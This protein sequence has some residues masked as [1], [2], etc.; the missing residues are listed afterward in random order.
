MNK[1]RKCS[2]IKH[3]ESKKSYFRM[4][5]NLNDYQFNIDYDILRMLQMS[6]MVTTKSVIGTEEIK[7]QA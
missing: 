5:S 3:G 7:S 4:C 1:D 6:L 2:Y